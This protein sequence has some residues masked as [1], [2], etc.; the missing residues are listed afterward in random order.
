MTRV[1]S[2]PL[3]LLALSSACIG[4]PVVGERDPDDAVDTGVCED[5]ELNCSE[6]AL[7]RDFPGYAPEEFEPREPCSERVE[8]MRADGLMMLDN[9]DL[10]CATL[11]LTLGQEADVTLSRPL[12]QDANLVL[13]AEGV[14]FVTLL[15][16]VGRGASVEVQGGATLRIF[17]ADDVDDLRVDAATPDGR[18]WNVEIE[19]GAIYRPAIRTGD[20][21]RLVV[22]SS[23]LDD[24]TLLAGELSVQGLRLRAAVVEARELIATGSDFVDSDVRVRR[25]SF[26]AGTMQGVAISGCESLQLGD[27]LINESDLGSCAAGPLEVRNTT[28]T[29]S[30]VRGRVFA[31]Q[32][33]L[34]ESLLG[35]EQGGWLSLF[36]SRVTDS[37]LCGVEALAARGG[38]VLLCARC[39]P[40]SPATSCIDESTLVAV[41]NCP[42]VAQAMRC[43]GELPEVLRLPADDAQ[44]GDATGSPAPLDGP[45]GSPP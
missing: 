34:Q 29:R 43:E 23:E 8:Q 38:T 42:D 33:R 1:R 41:V 44:A 14:G 2:V 25:G 5:D 39:F 18:G 11:E 13:I 6:Y 4:R 3:L 19:D 26:S 22:R 12:I 35:I 27:S 30:A 7:Q 16:P 32:S 21:G 17:S 15:S 31:L 45:G 20:G 37:V 36:D 9:L 40:A 10:R 24:A 28:I